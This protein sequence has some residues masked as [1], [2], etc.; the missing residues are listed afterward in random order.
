[1]DLEQLNRL[2]YL[3]NWDWIEE[4]NQTMRETTTSPLQPKLRIWKVTSYI[5][6]FNMY[7][8]QK[9]ARQIKC[10]NRVIY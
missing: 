9:Y 3:R 6:Y 2:F 4:L 5:I 7:N 1:M 10:E 8:T